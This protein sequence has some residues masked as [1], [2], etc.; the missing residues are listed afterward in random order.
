[1]LLI[2]EKKRFWIIFF[3]RGNLVGYAARCGDDKWRLFD[4]AYLRLPE[5]GE[6]LR[7]KQALDEFKRFLQQSYNA[8]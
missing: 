7:K 8:F 6:H 3:Y 5:A 2:Q 1:M 4:Q